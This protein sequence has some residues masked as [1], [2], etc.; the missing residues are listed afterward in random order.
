MVSAKFDFDHWFT[1]SGWVMSAYFQKFR[2]ERD[3][4]LVNLSAIHSSVPC[5]TFDYSHES[6]RALLD[7]YLPVR[8][9]HPLCV[10]HVTNQGLQAWLTPAHQDGVLVYALFD[11]T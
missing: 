2:K 6:K 10:N 3:Q 1:N 7:W 5:W 4:H 8:T 9:A 11:E